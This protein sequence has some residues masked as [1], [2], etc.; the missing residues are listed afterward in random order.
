MRGLAGRIW[1]YPQLSCWVKQ[2]IEVA[3]DLTLGAGVAVLV[4]CKWCL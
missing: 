1:F 3:D 2:D 4:M